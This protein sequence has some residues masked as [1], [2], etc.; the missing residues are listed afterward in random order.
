ML[1]RH[2]CRPFTAS[3]FESHVW[4]AAAAG[5]PGPVTCAAG[6]CAQAAAPGGRT[7]GG[8]QIVCVV[9]F[10]L[11]ERWCFRN[12]IRICLCRTVNGVA[13]FVTSACLVMCVGA[14]AYCVLEQGYQFQGF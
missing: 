13:A 3:L 10:S 6:G 8:N 12:L 5:A 2:A 7:G 4:R 9:S 11:S 14:W 1:F